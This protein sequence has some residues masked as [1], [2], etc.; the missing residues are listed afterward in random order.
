M[1]VLCAMLHLL[2]PLHKIHVKQHVNPR[3]ANNALIAACWYGDKLHRRTLSSGSWNDW[4]LFRC[5]CN[6]FNRFC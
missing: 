3:D 2:V 5:A 6:D 1:L 4:Q